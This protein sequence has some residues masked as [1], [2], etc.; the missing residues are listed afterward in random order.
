[1]EN[2]DMAVSSRGIQKLDPVGKLFHDAWESYKAHFST[3]VKILIIP[4]VLVAAGNLIATRGG[5][6]VAGAGGLISFIGLIIL[7][8]AGIAL[9]F[10]VIAGTDFAE[11][12]RRSPGVFWS[13]V[14]VSILGGVIT[15]GGLVMLIVPGIMMGIWFVFSG[16]IVIAENRR[17]LNTLTQSREYTRGYWWALL[18]RLL[19]MYL[20][21]GIVCVV[22]SVPLTL[23]FGALV[24]P[25]V[26]MVFWIFVVPFPVVYIYMIYKNLTVVKSELVTTQSSASRGF[27][28]ASGIVGIVGIVLIPILLISVIV[29]ALTHFAG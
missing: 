29:L 8:F 26:N 6:V 3:F 15:L 5:A 7:I 23:I 18:G 9:M 22:I 28:K 2:S 25:V 10:A 16:Y 1:M 13:L 14:W 21:V 20:A 4:S 17:G 19:L 11:S 27:L 12:Y 24:V